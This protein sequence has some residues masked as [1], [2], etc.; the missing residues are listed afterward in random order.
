MSGP[1]S[2][3]PLSQLYCERSTKLDQRLA[4]LADI[5]SDCEL[6]DK[7]ENA[8]LLGQRF[9]THSHSN[10]LILR[11]QPSEYY[12]YVMSPYLRVKSM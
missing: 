9:G 7:E 1:P 8:D 5:D 3:V 11:V 6:T 12:Y 4:S 10:H 2:T